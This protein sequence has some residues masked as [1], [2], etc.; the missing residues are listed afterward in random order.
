MY[1]H[2]NISLRSQLI[3]VVLSLAAGAYASQHPHTFIYYFVKF[4][5][6]PTP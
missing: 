4:L 2:S 1:K 3:G 6:A 5:F